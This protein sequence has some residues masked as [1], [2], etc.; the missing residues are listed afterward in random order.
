MRHWYKLQHISRN[1]LVADSFVD[2]RLLLVIKSTQWS[3]KQ[4]ETPVYSLQSEKVLTE[5]CYYL[6]LLIWILYDICFNHLE[7]RS[8]SWTICKWKSS[9]HYIRQLSWSD[10][11]TRIHFREMKTRLIVTAI[12][13]WL[14][15]IG[16]V[17]GNELN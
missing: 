13:H 14:F 11:K 17:Q 3:I 9:C 1:I 7:R 15:T 10:K 2:E 16:T 12:L 4:F 6:N 8:L 5:V